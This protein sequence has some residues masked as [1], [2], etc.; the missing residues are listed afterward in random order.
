[1]GVIVIVFD[2]LSV[3][4]FLQTHNTQIKLTHIILFQNPIFSLP[5]Y[6]RPSYLLLTK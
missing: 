6:K 4:S 3:G 2:L 1:M 5:V